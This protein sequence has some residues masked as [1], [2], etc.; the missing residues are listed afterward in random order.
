MF[1]Q[2]SEND[3]YERNTRRHGLPDNNACRRHRLATIFTLMMVPH[4]AHRLAALH[5][6]LSRRS[7]AAIKSINRN[8]NCEQ[9]RK[10]CSGKHHRHQLRSVQRIGQLG[11]QRR[12]E[13]RI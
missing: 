8:R 4:A 1:L 7:W 3:V 11:E 9:E 2:Y 6:L 5:R 10:D 12:G 13:P